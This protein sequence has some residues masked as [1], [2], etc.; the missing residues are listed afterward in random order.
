VPDPSSLGIDIRVTR[1]GSM[2]FEGATT[3][4]RM[5][6]TVPDLV[7][8]L[9]A[10][11]DFPA[12]A[13]LSTGTGIVPGLDFT[14]LEGDVVEVTVEHVGT[15]ANPVGTLAAARAAGALRVRTTGGR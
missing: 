12:G 1:A 15:L 11:Q 7:A 9:V 8:H 2:V 4:A 6:R 3:T 5:R 13:V 14:L 10:A